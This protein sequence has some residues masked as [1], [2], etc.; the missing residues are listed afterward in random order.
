MVVVCEITA[1]FVKFMKL[2]GG[3]TRRDLI[4]DI[5]SYK[6]SS[7]ISESIFRLDENN[8][9]HLHLMNF[10]FEEHEGLSIS[11]LSDYRDLAFTID[12]ISNIGDISEE[13]LEII[14]TAI[15]KNE[16]G[17]YIGGVIHTINELEDEE[18]IKIVKNIV[19][20]YNIK[21]E[22]RKGSK[23]FNMM[24]N[25]SIGYTIEL[26]SIIKNINRDVYNCI[27]ENIEKLINFDLKTLNDIIGHIEH[28]SLTD[29]LLVESF[30][31]SGVVEKC[32]EAKDNETIKNISLGTFLT[33]GNGLDP[34]YSGRKTLNK[35]NIQTILVK[36]SEYIGKR[37]AKY[38]ENFMANVTTFDS[39]S[40]DEIER[41]SHFNFREQSFVPIRPLGKGGSSNV[42]LVYDNDMQRECAIKIL[43]A[44]KEIE[45]ISSDGKKEMEKRGAEEIIRQEIKARAGLEEVKDFPTFYKRFEIKKGDRIYKAISLEYIPGYDL[46]EKIE[47]GLTE[48]QA[49]NYSIQIAKILNKI[50]KKDYVFGD[51]TK[52]NVRAN[53]KGKIK[54]LDLAHAKHNK[55]GIYYG[56]E[57]IMKGSRLYHAPERCLGEQHYSSDCFSF[58][59]LLF[60]M[61]SDGKN[62][63]EEMLKLIND[64]SH[65]EDPKN[66]IE[67]YLLKVYKHSMGIRKQRKNKRLFN[68]YN[69]SKKMVIEQHIKKKRLEEI[70]SKCLEIIPEDRYHDAGEV[71]EELRKID[72]TNKIIKTK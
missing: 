70:I 1:E 60:E 19:E 14:E 51:L 29:S 49:L 55:Y 8:K 72:Y 50:H 40:L 4:D 38:F 33:V 26:L 30:F 53:L 68:K 43:L 17:H 15:K 10:L 9:M 20:T 23:Q 22:F 28:S 58:G 27:K 21:S 52:L 32:I 39:E 11:N 36:L 34:N 5:Y 2:V 7:H 61:F 63:I 13:K 31:N 65:I 48:R 46:K 54:F 25:T 45:L 6:E 47:Q 35:T 71:L 24:E 42:I 3:Y 69:L 37:N 64:V 59:I 66:S 57:G 12:S 56:S 16:C 44:P 67:K 18:M 41:I 62:P